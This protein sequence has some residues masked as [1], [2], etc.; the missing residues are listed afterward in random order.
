MAFTAHSETASVPLGYS[1]Y[2]PWRGSPSHTCCARAK[3][4]AN[5]AVGQS[6][7]VRILAD[8]LSAKT[9]KL[10]NYITTLSLFYI[11]FLRSSE[12]FPLFVLHP[13]GLESG[14]L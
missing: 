7:Y 6:G 10:D 14:T 13:T 11:R 1:A 12:S 4:T 5:G 9:A 8:I 3:A 2:H